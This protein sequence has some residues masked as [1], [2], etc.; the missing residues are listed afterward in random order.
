MSN[1]NNAAVEIGRGSM[2]QSGIGSSSNVS[3]SISKSSKRMGYPTEQSIG[4]FGGV[5]WDYF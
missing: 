3:G 5:L 1:K 4:I 2:S